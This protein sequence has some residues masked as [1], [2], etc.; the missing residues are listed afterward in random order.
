MKGKNILKILNICFICLACLFLANTSVQAKKSKERKLLWDVEEGE[1]TKGRTMQEFMNRRGFFY[2][3]SG[4]CIYTYINH[5]KEVKIIGFKLK[6]KKVKIPAKIHGKKVTVIELFNPGEE[7][8][9]LPQVKHIIIPR[10]VKEISVV[11]KHEIFSYQ[12]LKKLEK[13]EVS[14]K[15]NYFKSKD[16]ILFS[17]DGKRLLNV[18][19]RKKAANYLIPYG[20]KSIADHCFASCN[21]IQAVTMPDT[22]ERVGDQGFIA[23]GIQKIRLSRNLKSMGET[24]LGYTKL[25]EAVIP[26]SLAEVPEDC[27][28]YCKNLKKVTLSPG[29]RSIGRYAFVQCKNLKKVI[30]PPSVKKF[31]LNAFV[32]TSKIMTLKKLTIYAKKTS[33]AYKRAQKW[34]KEYQYKVKSY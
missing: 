26:G 17:K 8:D 3:E 24:A 10:Y 14:S 29:V 27:L 5:K 9:P 18:P 4:N 32:Y 6:A 7:G 2:G 28:E 20:V 34:K 13:Y 30:I 33:Y 25:T 1:K 15:N 12:V 22:V 16:G 23:S 31:G 19:R 21:R 11:F